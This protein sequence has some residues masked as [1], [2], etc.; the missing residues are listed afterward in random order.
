MAAR[1][2]F[3]ANLLGE[4][5]L[6]FDDQHRS[7][8]QRVRRAGFLERRN[9]HRFIPKHHAS[10]RPCLTSKEAP[11][12]FTELAAW[13]TRFATPAARGLPLIKMI[14]TSGSDR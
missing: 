1:L 12:E 7:A 5:A 6:V 11:Q 4:V 2:Q 13:S 14:L 3:E 9:A 10:P 8:R